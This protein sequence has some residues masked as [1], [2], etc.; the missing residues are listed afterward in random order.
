MSRVALCTIALLCFAPHAL[1][2]DQAP[3]TAV[4]TGEAV[5]RRPPDVAYIGIAVETRA[6]TPREAQ[7]ATA[8]IMSAVLKRLTDAGVVRD[9]M[10]TTGLRV[11]QE[12]DFANGK[13]T[14]R[15]FVARNAIELRVDDVARTGELS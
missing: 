11:E 3:M 10:R 14:S 8:D 12:F 4:S 9:A 7:T 2:Q 1:A 15:G 13:R 5:V 6:R